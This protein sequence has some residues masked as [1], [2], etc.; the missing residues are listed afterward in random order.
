MGANVAETE[1]GISVT[2]GE[3]RAIT[4]DVREIPDLVPPVA[5]LMSVA[6]GESRI[7]G[8][9]RLRLKE[10]DRLAAVAQTINALGG[11]AE[12]TPD[13]LI[14]RGV[15]S[16]TGGSVD[17]FNDHRIAMSAALAAA[18]CAA[19]VTISNAEAVEKSYPKF[20]GEYCSLLEE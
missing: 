7:T 1:R 20:Y 4:L 6:R 11:H 8:G 19:P 13:G 16:L 2:G 10:S 14:I 9:A 18:W 12:E 17:S 3:L 15:Q 5:V